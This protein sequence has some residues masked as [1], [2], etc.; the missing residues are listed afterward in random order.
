MLGIVAGLVGVVCWPSTSVGFATAQGRPSLA[1]RGSGAEVRQPRFRRAGTVGQ[2]LIGQGYVFLGSATNGFLGG[3]LIN[4]RTG[5]RTE[6]VRPDCVAE[7]FG[8]PWLLFECG[9]PT[10]TQ[11]ALYRLTTRT[12]RLV[13]WNGDRLGYPEAVGAY[14]IESLLDPGCPDTHCDNV[15][16][17]WFT[18]IATGRQAT[19]AWHPGGNIVP[20]LDSPSLAHKLCAPLRVPTVWVDIGEG[21]VPLP[22][23]LSM[24]GS[25]A[26]A[27]GT[28]RPGAQAPAV[29]WHTYVERCHSKLRRLII[30]STF[31]TAGPEP[32][33]APIGDP[34]A[35]VWP[36]QPQ[37]LT[38]LF[39][40]SLQKF[41]MTVPASIGRVQGTVGPVD[42][43]FLASRT[44][45]VLNGTQ[46]WAAPAPTPTR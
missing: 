11:V 42:Q 45:Y 10:V 32:S 35:I 28:T 37:Q 2:V 46:L 23:T 13:K 31:V 16:S 17:Y 18:R 21:E 15:P 4:E 27:S 6:I 14:W 9:N 22:G 19:V 29:Q 41:T 8:G 34:H 36:S 39:L 24:L 30:E 43:T 3:T 12:W 7:F 40:P 26:I 38:G 33:R 25:F 5:K 44:L 20:G 1:A